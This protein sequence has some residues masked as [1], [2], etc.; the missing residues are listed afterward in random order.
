MNAVL[1]RLSYSLAGI[2]ATFGFITW[3]SFSAF[4]GVILAIC[5]LLVNWHYKAR[6]D[7]REQERHLLEIER[8]KKKE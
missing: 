7:K 2:M 3:Q 6:E 8:L 5:T 4:V 1:D